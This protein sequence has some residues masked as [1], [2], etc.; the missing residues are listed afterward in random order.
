MFLILGQGSSTKKQKDAIKALAKQVVYLFEQ[1]VKNQELSRLQKEVQERNENLEKFAALVSHD[2]KSPLAQI[3]SL[4]QLIEME[5]SDVLGE[6]IDA[7]L[8]YIKVASASLR[9]Y[10]DDMLAFYKSDEQ[11]Y[12]QKTS[13]YIGDFTDEL[14]SICSIDGNVVWSV[15]STLTRINTNKLALQQ[16]LVNLV[17]NAIKYNDSPH[18]L[19]KLIFKEDVE[20][21]HISVVDNG[22]GIQQ[23]HL[24][25]IFDM[26]Y[27]LKTEDASGNQGTGIGLAMVKRIV[28]KLNGTIKVES[29]EGE[30]SN[31][32][33]TI[34]K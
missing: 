3:T 6:S 34:P 27:T 25:K 16:V 32:I 14:K 13:I 15:D 12:E 20:N 17:T 30:G 23:M 10:I 19:V 24:D 21:Y 2:L 22:K 29:K 1:R 7:Y 9:K 18:P 28:D 5:S 33:L 11:S 26:F 8:S 31:F 4:I